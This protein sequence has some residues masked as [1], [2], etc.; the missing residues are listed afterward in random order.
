MIKIKKCFAVNVQQIWLIAKA[1]KIILVKLWKKKKKARDLPY[2]VGTQTTHGLLVFIILFP[3]V[4][5]IDKIGAK[6]FDMIWYDMVPPIPNHLWGSQELNNNLNM[7]A[8]NSGTIL[9]LHLHP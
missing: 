3:Y 5:I 7:P 4:G 1:K 8:T 2:V 9:P 6:L